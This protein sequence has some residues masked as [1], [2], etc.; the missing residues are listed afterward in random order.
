MF[1]A[2]TD[3]NFR[4]YA[5]KCYSNGECTIEEF[6][7]DLKRFSYLRRLFHRYHVDNVLRERLILNHLIVIFNVFGIEG[8]LR[9]TFYKVDR[10]YWTYLK[11]FLLFLNYLSKYHLKEIETDKYINEMLLGI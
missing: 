1:S 7:E 9:M 8:G 10:A 2:L 11:T 3:E 5:I 6:E 4:D